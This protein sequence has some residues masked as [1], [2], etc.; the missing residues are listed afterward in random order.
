MAAHR[1][2]VVCTVTTAKPLAAGMAEEVEGALKGFLKANEKALITYKVDPSIVGGMVGVQRLI[3]NLFS[4]QQSL[5][6]A[7]TGLG[8]AK[9]S[10]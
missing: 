8:L 7:V 3:A 9:K 2:E 1:G 10:F 5:S 6:A 4:A